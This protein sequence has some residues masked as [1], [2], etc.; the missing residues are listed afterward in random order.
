MSNNSSII[1]DSDTFYYSVM[2]RLILWGYIGLVASILG[3]I[4]NIITILI[5]LSP[6]MRT[7]STHIYLTALSCSDII[8]LLMYIPSYSIRYLVNYRIYLERGPT[9]TFDI[10]LAQVPLTFLYNVILFSNIYITIAVAIDRL[11]SVKYPLRARQFVTQRTT[12]FVI[13][14]IYIFSILSC[15]PFWFERQYNPITKTCQSTEFGRATYQYIRVYFYIPMFCVI[16]FVS[17]IYINLNILQSLIEN[18]QRKRSLGIQSNTRRQIDSNITLMLVIIIIISVIC[19]LPLTIRNILNTF[20]TKIRLQPLLIFTLNAI[21]ILI[22]VLNTLS[23]FLL[24]CLFLQRF[25]QILIEM[26]LRIYSRDFQRRY[27]PT[28]EQS[29]RSNTFELMPEATQKFL[30]KYDFKSTDDVHS[31]ICRTRESF[32][33]HNEGTQS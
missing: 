14:F 3:I 18:K 24:S 4:G 12:I 32:F 19:Y 28:S 7:V 23:N 29:R 1:H 16:P 6:S 15:I 25:R 9:S 21:V 22:N 10:R 26:F 31:T 33:S 20:Y 27:Y 2:S 5:L 11:V 17:L 8:Y 30:G 13:I